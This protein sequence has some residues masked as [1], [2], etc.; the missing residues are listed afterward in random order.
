MSSWLGFR[1]C[2]TR[3]FPIVTGELRRSTRTRQG[4]AGLSRT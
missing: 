3:L 4:Q 1:S 2:S